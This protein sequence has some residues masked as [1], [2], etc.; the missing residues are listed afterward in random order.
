MRN[1]SKYLFFCLVLLLGL[2]AC[3]EA[4]ESSLSE[5]VLQD[6]LEIHKDKVIDEVI[7]C[8]GNERNNVEKV[9]VYYYPIVGSSN[10]RYYETESAAVNPNDFSNYKLKELPSEGVFGDKLSFF[11]R[12]TTYEAWGIVTF[13]TEGKIHKSNPIRLK[14]QTKPTIYTENIVIDTSQ[15]GTP[16]FQWEESSYRE[17]AIYFQAL[18]TNT[19]EFISGTYTIEKCFRYYDTSNVVLDINLGTPPTL[20]T[21]A[22]YQ[23]NILGV[24]EDNWV[25]VHARQTF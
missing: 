9:F 3:S 21:T 4:N 23:M 7:A 20:N 17:D 18:V 14:Q 2:F 6:Y 16:K 22:E 1:T 15:N 10:Y 19:N 13:L 25:N 11:T 8:A 5:T 24:S 12:E